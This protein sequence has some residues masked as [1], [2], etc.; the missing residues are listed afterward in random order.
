MSRGQSQRHHRTPKELAEEVQRR[1]PL[2]PARSPHR[3]Q[4]RLCP[5]ACPGPAASPD[6]AQDDLACGMAVGSRSRPDSASISTRGRLGPQLLFTAQLAIMQ[7]DAAARRQ[8][9][10]FMQL[11]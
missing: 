11:D 6:L 3:H 4:D 1:T 8:G 2:L 9:S 10:A 7:L 5:S